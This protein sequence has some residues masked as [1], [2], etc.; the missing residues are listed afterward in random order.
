[1]KAFLVAI[2]LVALGVLV[3]T[4][5]RGPWQRVYHGWFPPKHCSPKAIESTFADPISFLLSRA[6]LLSAHGQVIVE[7][8]YDGQVAIYLG[9]Y[10]AIEAAMITKNGE[11]T[12]HRYIQPLHLPSGRYGNPVPGKGGVVSIEVL[13]SGM[14]CAYEKAL[15]ANSR[16]DVYGVRV[17]FAHERLSGPSGP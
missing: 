6:E 9:R 5:E 16:G 17:V 11:G 1:M 12:F 7:D 4:W 2:I 10:P 8:P 13:P 3:A 14:K 15:V